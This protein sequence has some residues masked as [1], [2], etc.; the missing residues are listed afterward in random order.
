[1]RR[2][3]E[4]ATALWMLLVKDAKAIKDYLVA[5]DP[6]LEPHHFVDEMLR[7]GGT[8]L[9]IGMSFGFIS[10]LVRRL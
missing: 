6:V 1:V 4:A 9:T 2:Q 10:T 3:S 8:K 5:L 7:S